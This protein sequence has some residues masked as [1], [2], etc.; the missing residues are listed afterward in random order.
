[1]DTSIDCYDDPSGCLAPVLDR[2]RP[3]KALKVRAFVIVE[4]EW[5]RHFVIQQLFVLGV[6]SRHLVDRVD[7]EPIWL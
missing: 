4:F 7:D 2:A 6:Q 3:D 5:G 1:M